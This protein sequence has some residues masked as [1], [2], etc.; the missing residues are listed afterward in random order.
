MPPGFR[1][2]V[3]QA[4]V[5]PDA[6]SGLR[7]LVYS[8]GLATVSLFI[9]PAVAASEQAEGLSQIGAANAYTTTIRGHMITA[10][11]E[12]PVRTVEMFARSR[13]APASESLPGARSVRPAAPADG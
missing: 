1:L 11:G 12:V 9:E 3:R 7:H 10:V 4:K 5:A 13:D 8:D 2:T 6:G